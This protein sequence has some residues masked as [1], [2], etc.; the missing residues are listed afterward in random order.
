VGSRSWRDLTR[1]QANERRDNA[2]YVVATNSIAKN[3]GA[4]QDLQAWDNA[5][6][7]DPT[8]SLSEGGRG[9]QQAS[10]PD[11]RPI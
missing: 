9:A 5:K 7:S 11:L 4:A 8:D 2:H 6:P 10:H 3:P 1:R